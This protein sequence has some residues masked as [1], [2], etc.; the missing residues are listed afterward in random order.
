MHTHACARRHT[1]A[2]NNSV[3]VVVIEVLIT[4]LA[5]AVM[6]ISAKGFLFVWKYISFG[7]L[8]KRNIHIMV[9]CIFCTDPG[10]RGSDVQGEE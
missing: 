8:N 10:A 7:K 5:L 9:L 2:H 6:H 1:H 3:V 4:A